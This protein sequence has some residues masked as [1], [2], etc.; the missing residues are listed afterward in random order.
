MRRNKALPHRNP[1][2]HVNRRRKPPS[3][4]GSSHILGIRLRSNRLNRK[5]ARKLKAFCHNPA[6]RQQLLLALVNFGNLQVF[7]RRFVKRQPLEQLPLTSPDQRIG[8]DRMLHRRVRHQLGNVIKPPRFQTRIQRM[9][10]IPVHGTPVRHFCSVVP[11]NRHRL[12][13]H[14]LNLTRNPPS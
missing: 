8:I 6:R 5:L 4:T 12:E 2:T 1:P 9:I 3:W 14:H 10:D 11:H 13:I 7:E